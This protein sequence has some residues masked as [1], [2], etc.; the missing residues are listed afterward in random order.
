MA[1]KS[2]SEF[3]SGRKPYDSREFKSQAGTIADLGGERL[4]WHFSSITVAE[5]SVAREEI[6]FEREKFAKLAH[7]LA[8]YA[9]QVGTAAEE[10][11]TM[12]DSMRMRP[13]E[14]TE[15]GPFARKQREEPDV[16]SFSSEHAFHMMLQTCATC[17]AAFR[18]KQ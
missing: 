16:V 4:I 1:A 7:D 15:G 2:I 12:P 13:A 3:L 14:M 17:H 9:A 5:G 10:G 8:T 18:L 6:G 11:N